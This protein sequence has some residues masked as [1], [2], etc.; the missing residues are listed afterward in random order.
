[1]FVNIKCVEN[2]HG[3]YNSNVET[4]NVAAHVYIS[5][6]IFTATHNMAGRINTN[7]VCKVVN[8]VLGFVHRMRK[9]T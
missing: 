7:K 8:Y 6:V 5:Y 2:K 4:F 3:K 1:M 9:W